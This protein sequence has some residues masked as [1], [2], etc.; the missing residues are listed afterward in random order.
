MHNLLH[1]IV[2]ALE[3]GEP[4][5]EDGGST[6]TFVEGIVILG[7]LIAINFGISKLLTARA[8]RK[9]GDRYIGPE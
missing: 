9:Y 7:V 1:A 6:T 8:K 2:I 5:N 4:Y 3:N